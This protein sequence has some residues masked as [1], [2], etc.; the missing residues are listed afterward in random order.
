MT[1]QSLKPDQEYLQ[2]LQ[3]TDQQEIC[4]LVQHK[5][6]NVFIRIMEEK[7]VGLLSAEE[8]GN[9]PDDAFAKVKIREGFGQALDLV[10]R[11]SSREE[12]E[13]GMAIHEGKGERAYVRGRRDRN[14]GRRGRTEEETGIQLRSAPYG[15]GG[16]ESV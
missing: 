4:S 1:D 3:K 9:S 5:G 11:I 16:A 13:N 8:S 2:H 12:L 10:Y 7:L 14:E 6:W 15:Y